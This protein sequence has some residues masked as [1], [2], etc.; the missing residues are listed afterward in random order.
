MDTG[1]VA[2]MLNV[3]SVQAT[4]IRAGPGKYAQPRPAV[5][6]EVPLGQRQFVLQLLL[7]CNIV[8]SDCSF[9]LAFLST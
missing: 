8:G 1:K 7:S 6:R 9:L 2:D 5:Y 3:D 4:A